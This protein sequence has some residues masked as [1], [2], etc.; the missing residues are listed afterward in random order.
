M[1][2]Q[3]MPMLIAKVD[4]MQQ[5]IQLDVAQK[6]TSFEILLKENISQVCKSKV[7]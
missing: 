2:R 3:V 4:G 1:Q 5:Q 7:R 6:L